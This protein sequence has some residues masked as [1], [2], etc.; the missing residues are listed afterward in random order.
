MLK[1]ELLTLNFSSLFISLNVSTFVLINISIEHINNMNII[2]IN[3]NQIF[4]K[5]LLCEQN[6][7]SVTYYYVL[8]LKCTFSQ[9]FSKKN[10]V[11]LLIN[12]TYT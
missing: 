1:L 9:K 6:T 11:Y 4:E 12:Y 8:I 10:C 2:E 7:H 5:Q 3:F